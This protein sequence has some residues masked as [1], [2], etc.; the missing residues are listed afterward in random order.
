MRLE[1]Y[2]NAY[3]YNLTI[4]TNFDISTASNI[5]LNCKPRYGGSVKSIVCTAASTSDVT[6][7]VTDGFFDRLGVWDCQVVATFASSERTGEIFEIKVI[8]EIV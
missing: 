8:A 2:Q 5:A 1:V 6:A 4:D 3:G 7:A